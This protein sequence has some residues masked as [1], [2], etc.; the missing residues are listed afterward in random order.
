[1]PELP[2]GSIELVVTSPPYWKIK[3]YGARGQI[4]YG[5]SL[6]A[7]LRRSPPAWAECLRV[8]RRGRPA[9]RE[10]RRPVRPRARLRP[11]PRHPPARGDH[12]PVRRAG[13]RLPGLHHLAE[14]D[15]HEHLGRRGGHGVLPL[16]PNGIVEIDFEY[17]LLF[18]KAGEG[19]DGAARVKEAA[20]LSRDEWKS[21]FSGHW[22]VGGARKAGHEAPFPEEIPRRLIRMFSFPGDTV[23]DPFLGTGTTAA[24]ALSWT[25]M[26]WDTRS[27]PTMCG[28]AAARL[29]EAGARADDRRERKGRGRGRARRSGWRPSVPDMEPA[30]PQA[31]EPLSSRPAHRESR[32]RGLHPHPRYRRPCVPS[33]PAHPRPAGGAC[34]PEAEGA[35][36][37]GLP[38]GR[39]HRERARPCAPGSCSRTGFRSTPTC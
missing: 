26:P 20:A 37:E 38:Q 18:R 2:D 7:Y 1:M 22:D 8:L 36:E 28:M 4:G 14:E 10:H 21:W 35:Q 23:L 34:L 17:I 11:L 12:L 15:H 30:A 25:A 19:A 29:R 6:H 5:Q 33:R 24:V 3:D 32:E 9:V 16:P 13:L 27:T 39:D 31:D